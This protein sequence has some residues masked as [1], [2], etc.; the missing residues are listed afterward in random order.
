MSDKTTA[1]I[2]AEQQTE[3]PEAVTE[4]LPSVTLDELDQV[5]LGAVDQGERAP[6]R[7][8]DDRCAD[9]AIRKIAEE[10][11]EYSRLKEL[12]DQQK[13]AIDEKVEA[14]RRRMENGTAFLTSCLADFFNTVPHKTTKT[15]EKYRLLSGTLTL[16]KGGV[17]AK[18]DDA[19]LVPWL[20][21]NGYGNLVK[22]EES[23]KWGELKKL[24]TY[25]GEIAT[26]E[27]TGEIVEGGAWRT[28]RHDYLSIPLWARADSV[29]AAGV[30]T[31]DSCAGQGKGTDI[32]AGWGKE[33]DES[34]SESGGLQDSADG[35]GK[36]SAGA[37]D[38]SFR[39]NLELKVFF[40]LSKAETVVYQDN[41]E[42]VRAVFEREG[43]EIKG[44]VSGGRGCRVRLVGRRL[45]GIDGASMEI[46]GQDTVITLD[47][48]EAVFSG[49]I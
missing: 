1:A 35:N 34:R 47:E 12:A 33:A 43:T 46:Q 37:A 5:D 19:K 28:E 38:Y 42:I 24:L 25:T 39:G 31:K 2:A 18:Q 21:A 6:F 44:R 16:K 15:T 23:A 20:K 9:W 10:R 29:V 7:I 8:T 17:K 11:G 30:C 48:D 14:A 27:S 36:A 32:S 26:I 13:A 3:T 45:S 40:L 4:A 41:E 49:K 22:V